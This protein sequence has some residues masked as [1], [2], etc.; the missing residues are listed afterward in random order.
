MEHLKLVSRES[1][2]WQ[3]SRLAAQD[4]EANSFERRS[5]DSQGGRRRWQAVTQLWGEEEMEGN[6]KVQDLKDRPWKKEELKNLEEDMPRLEEWSW[7]GSEIL[8]SQYRSGVR[9]LSFQSSS[10]FDKKQYEKIW[11][12]W[13]RWSSVGDA[14]SKL[15]QRLFCM[16]P[17]NVTSER[18]IALMPKM[19]R[20]WEALRAPEVAKWERK[21]CVEL[22]ATD[23]R[24]GGAAL[25]VGDLA[26]VGKIQTLCRR[27]RSR[28]DGTVSWLGES[29]PAG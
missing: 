9:C 1:H 12:S 8:Q 29:F 15:A 26:G 14:R 3:R 10:G 22:G 5:A 23:G 28:S 21:Y 7:K 16:I 20:W 25:C 4:H 27:Q 11:N 24:N 6:T 13:R 2:C 18:P 17:K 19:N